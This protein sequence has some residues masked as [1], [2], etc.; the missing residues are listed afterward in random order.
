MLATLANLP[1]YALSSVVLLGAFS[2]ITHGRY[3]PGWYA[4][5]EYHAP[6]DGSLVATITPFI[7]ALVGLSLLS[8]R[9]ALRL[10]AAAVSLIFFLMGLAMQVMA[11][12]EYKGDVA[13]IGIAALAVARSLRR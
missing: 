7:D 10:A 2:R 12:K 13:L 9:R 6:D 5:Q 3:T 1:V 8:G 4:F 11:G